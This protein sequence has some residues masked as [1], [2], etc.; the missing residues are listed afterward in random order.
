MIALR[1]DARIFGGARRHRMATP[2]VE[3]A[4]YS[5]G[6]DPAAA[7]AALLKAGFGAVKIESSALQ[8]HTRSPSPKS[9][10]RLQSAFTGSVRTAP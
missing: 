8:T 10:R 3:A 9:G 2:T 5:L 4:T 6:A 1:P 7:C